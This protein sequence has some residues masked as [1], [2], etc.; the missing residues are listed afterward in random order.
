MQGTGDSEGGVG[1]CVGP[2]GVGASQREAGGGVPSVEA[3]R[4][5]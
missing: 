3:G 5:A 4:P 1:A 2:S